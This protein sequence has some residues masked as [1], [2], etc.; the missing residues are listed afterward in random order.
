MTFLAIAKGPLGPKGKAEKTKRKR[1][2]GKDPDYLAAIHD[3]PCICCAILG[4]SQNTPTEAH[5]TICGRYSQRKTPDDQAIPLCR[6]HHTG[7]D[8]IHTR[9]KWWVEAFGNDT[10]YIEQTRERVNACL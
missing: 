5:H 1:A 3:L 6:N 4:I 8:G 2:D 9:R 7:P 10:D